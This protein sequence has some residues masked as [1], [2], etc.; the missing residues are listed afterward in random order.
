MNTRGNI[1]KI[2]CPVSLLPESSRSLS[3]AVLSSFLQGV[4]SFILAFDICQPFRYFWTRAVD[5][6]DGTCGDVVL[7]YKSCNIPSGIITCT[8]C[9]VAFFTIPLFA[10]PTWYAS[11]GPTIYALVE[12]S[13]YARSVKT[14]SDARNSS[15]PHDP[16]EP[17]RT[18]AKALEATMLHGK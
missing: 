17:R 12:P 15:P 7:F 10:D 2:T 13:I 16:Q 14:N 4:I 1:N 5:A 11:G 9:F 3:I 8:L 6:N 18:A